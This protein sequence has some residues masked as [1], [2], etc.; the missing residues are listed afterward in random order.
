MTSRQQSVPACSFVV[1][2]SY[3]IQHNEQSKCRRLVV[4]EKTEASDV[5][6]DLRTGSVQALD[7]FDT[8]KSCAVRGHH[9]NACCEADVVTYSSIISACQK[10]R[11]WE[12]AMAIYHVSCPLYMLTPSQLC[13]T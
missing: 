13:L 12:Q 3:L 7:V 6:C 1:K 10:S 5:P 2:A 9:P 8:M 11:Q 4:H